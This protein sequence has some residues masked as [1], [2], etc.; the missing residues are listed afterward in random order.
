VNSYMPSG[1]FHEPGYF[2]MALNVG[3]PELEQAVARLAS[4][5][6]GA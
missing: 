6:S 5:R 1:I 2:R 3:L 4:I